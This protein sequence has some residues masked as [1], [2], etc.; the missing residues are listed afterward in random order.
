MLLAEYRDH[1]CAQMSFPVWWRASTDSIYTISTTP[2]L[3]LGI[4]EV[5][6]RGDSLETRG[7]QNPPRRTGTQSIADIVSEME[8][9][10]HSG[11]LWGTYPRKSSAG[12]GDRISRWSRAKP[13]PEMR[14]RDW[15]ERVLNWSTR[16]LRSSRGPIAYP[17]VCQL[18]QEIIFGGKVIREA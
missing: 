8:L 16:S 17:E 13:R 1:L 10:H 9:E 2:P 18:L 14:S 15:V 11:Q 6:R 5:D 7:H 12:K 3:F 4:V